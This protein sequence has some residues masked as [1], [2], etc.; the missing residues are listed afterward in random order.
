MRKERAGLAGQ[1]NQAIRV[2]NWRARSAAVLGATPHAQTVS[3]G[4]E[5]Y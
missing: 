4:A 3:G 2:M 1:Q 5:N